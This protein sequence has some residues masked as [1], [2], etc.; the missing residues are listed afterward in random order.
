MSTNKA[1]SGGNAGLEKKNGAA[2]P[3]KCDN[4]GLVEETIVVGSM[5]KNYVN[6]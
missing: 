6:P 4:Q 3:G 5:R 1:R 2:R